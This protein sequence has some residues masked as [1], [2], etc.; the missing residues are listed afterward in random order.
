[1]SVLAPPAPPPAEYLDEAGDDAVAAPPPRGG[2]E[3]LLA[4]LRRLQTSD[5]DVDGALGLV[6]DKARTLLQTDLAWGGT[7]HDG[8]L[9]T[10]CTAGAHTRAFVTL[11]PTPLPMALSGV[12]LQRQHTLIV[13]D[14]PRS[15][16]LTTPQIRD[17]MAREGVISMMAAP[18]F[19]GDKLVGYVNVGNRHRTA[20]GAVH[21]S[22][23]STL[24]AQASIAMLNACLQ[25]ELH[26]SNALLAESLATHRELT[27]SALGTLGVDGLLE[28]LGQ[29]VDRRIELV[30]G[31]DP[32]PD[33]QPGLGTRIPVVAGADRLGWLCVHGP[34]LEPL[35]VHALHHGAAAMALELL[36]RRAVDEAQQRMRSELLEEMVHARGQPASGLAERA[37]RLGHDPSLPIR[38]A[39][40]SELGDA[41]DGEHVHH[42][43]RRLLEADAA[44]AG[45]DAPLS[46]H[47]GPHVVVAVPPA[48]AGRDAPE[49]LHARLS[50]RGLRLAVGVSRETH[51]RGAARAEA[52]AC[53]RLAL[54]AK[55]PAMVDAARLGPLRFLLDTVDCAPAAAS[56]REELGPLVAA[57]RRSRAPLF[58]TARAYVEADGHDQRGI[59]ARCAI[60]VNTL[61]YRLTRIDDALG[62]SLRDPDRR[63]ALRLAFAVTD[64]LERLGLDPLERKGPHG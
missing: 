35:Q 41:T 15:R 26:A 29:R 7:L 50:A 64:M 46:Y 37:I 38:L 61:K 63:F 1:M 36:S 2:L 47:R 23:L 39:A 17:A 22:L 53:L 57:E 40:F 10:E 25:S 5:A 4:V 8:Q 32:R 52:F 45:V 9:R 13:S 43:L 27:A 34:P 42:V 56:V 24:S 49:Q 6:V 12:A 20:F 30:V 51:D 58:E 54:Q 44:T 48:P 31:A 11:K 21:S 33:T 14:Y 62:G 60:H 55:T 3:E 16:H 28:S 59:A 18:L 19:R